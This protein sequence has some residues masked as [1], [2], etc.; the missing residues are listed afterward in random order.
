MLPFHLELA[1]GSPVSE[2]IVYA[3]KRAV[4]SGL[5]QIGDKFPSVR[6]LSQEL[7]VNP[8][9]AHKAIAALI[10]EGLLEVRPGIG[11]IVSKHPKATRQQR[12]ELLGNEVERLVVEAKQLRV[13]LEDVIRAVE[14][15]WNKLSES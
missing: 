3:V 9:T 12:S 5:L 10:A 14:R 8:N 6:T 1:T 4:I 15:N 2:Q 11:T 7:R 13:E